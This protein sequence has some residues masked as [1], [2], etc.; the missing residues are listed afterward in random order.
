MKDQ[1]I[2]HFIS[3]VYDEKGA[4][5]HYI[6]IVYFKWALKN[7]FQVKKNSKAYFIYFFGFIFGWYFIKSQKS[8]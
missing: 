8:G 5:D 2:P 1:N 6:G 3:I 7:G 4:I